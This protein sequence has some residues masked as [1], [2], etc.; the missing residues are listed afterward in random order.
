M[1]KLP[2]RYAAIVGLLIGWI[3]CAH[4]PA[5]VEGQL[6]TG[7]VI[8]KVVCAADATQSYALYLPSGYSAHKKWPIVYA[9][10]PGAQGQNPVE[11]MKALAEG[12][13]YIL[14]GSNNSRNGPWKPQGE[15]AQAMLDD[16]SSRLSID[17]RRVYFTG[18]SGGARVAGRVAVLC[19][20][21][22][23][24]VIAHGAGLN[25]DEGPNHVSFPLFLTIGDTDFNNEEVARLT[26][27]LEESGK[28]N[29]LRSFPGPTSGPPPKCGPK[30]SSGL[31]SWL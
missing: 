29:R 27:Q 26:Q 15:A 17:T 21:C 13:G 9:F 6:P 1:S 4:S 3:P 7:V 30:R 20:G 14:A 22:A 16:T 31:S 18:F 11:Q 23:A 19:Q 2:V 12:H 25:L 8:P 28:P 10:D 24:A 5:R